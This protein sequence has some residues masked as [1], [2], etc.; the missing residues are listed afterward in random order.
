MRSKAARLKGAVG[1]C[2]LK[3]LDGLVSISELDD[4]VDVIA[5]L[6]AYTRPQDPWTTEDSCRIANTV[7][8]AYVSTLRSQS[9][10][11]ERLLGAVLARFVKPAFSK[12]KNPA[13]TPAG[14][15]NL[16]PVPQPR[17]DATLFDKGSKPWKYRDI[18]IST[19]LFWIVDQYR[20]CITAS[21]SI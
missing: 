2:V 1:V 6:A 20:V 10:A 14:R 8:A 19:V 11:L 5:A 3:K 16:H 18:Y 9:G 4:P 13:I 17:F 15:K 7:L 21:P 12:T